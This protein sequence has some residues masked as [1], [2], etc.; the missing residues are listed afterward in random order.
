MNYLLAA[1]KFLLLPKLKKEGSNAVSAIFACLAAPVLIVMVVFSPGS[2]GNEDAYDKAYKSLGCPNDSSYLVED[3]RV[4]D[5]YADNNAF[6]HMTNAEAKDRMENIYLEISEKNGTKK[7][8]L[9]SD[10]SIKTAL[11]SKYSLSDSQIKEMM[12]NVNGVRN[13]RQTLISPLKDPYIVVG[14]ETTKDHIVFSAEK[15]AAVKS[16]GDGI[17]KNIYTDSSF[18]DINGESIQKGLTITIEYEIQK[19]IKEAQ[20]VTEKLIVE[21][22]MLTGTTLNTGD[23]VSAEQEISKLSSSYLFMR[24]KNT[25]GESLDPELY[26]YLD[27]YLPSGEFVIPFKTTPIVIGEVG[28]RDLTV[29]GTDFHYGMDVSVAAN[30]EVLAFTDGT[31]VKTSTNCAPFG[32]YI[33]N[34][35]PLDGV[36]Y[37]GGNYAMIAFKSN[38]KDYFGI[39]CH[40]SEVKVHVGDKVKAGQVIGKQGSSGMSSGTHLHIEIHEGTYDKVPVG[41]KKGLMDPREFIDFGDGKKPQK[42]N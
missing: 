1:L 21:Y 11:K 18:I 30:A 40:M 7:C 12:M 16:I 2:T 6:E 39:L 14:F 3:I 10:A 4:F 24:F 9:K 38:D 42:F 28:K 33:G 32:G 35:C 31:I 26:I 22:S 36:A 8:Y 23:A 37:G 34:T 15:K 27:D 25:K 19:G 41:F 29:F 20:Y 17:V 13:G 5:S